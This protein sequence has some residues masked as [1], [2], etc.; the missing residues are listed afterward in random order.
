[1]SSLPAEPSDIQRFSKDSNIASEIPTLE[2]NTVGQQVVSGIVSVQ[3]TESLSA[4][5]PN[6][7][8]N[9]KKTASDPVSTN[10]SCILQ[11]ESNNN[12]QVSTDNKNMSNKRLEE[13][14]KWKVSGCK[15][16]PPA[17]LK[18]SQ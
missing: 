12:K 9:H 2:D 18:I 7:E 16:D 8:V 10:E 6:L 1:M 5:R 3:R 13:Y 15:G 4:E 11:Q 17:K 14:H